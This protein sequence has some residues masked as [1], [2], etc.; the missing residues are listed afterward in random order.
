MP[1]WRPL[2][3]NGIRRVT[4]NC[5]GRAGFVGVILIS[6]IVLLNSARFFLGVRRGRRVEH[7]PG[8][9]VPTPLNLFFG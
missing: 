6:K 2:S 9:L 8:D 7:P 1:K 4:A 3:P 5:L